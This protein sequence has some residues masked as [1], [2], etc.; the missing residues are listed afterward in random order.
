[1][2]NLYKDSGVD[3]KKGD[4]L[5]EWLKSTEDEPQGTLGEAVSGIGG[6]AALF[7]PN[8]HGMTD[9]LLV[10]STDGVGTKVLLGIEGNALDGLGIDLVAMCINDLYTVG[11]RPLF[12]LDYFAT[13]TLEENQFKAILS[14]IKR[15]LNEANCMLLG[16]ETAEL[17]GLYAKQHFDLAG[18]VVGVVDGN[19]RLGPQRVRV[20]DHLIAFR[21]SGFHSNGYS[22]LRRWWSIQKNPELFKKLIEPTKIYAALPTLLDEF[23]CETL[24]AV[25]HITGGG[26]SG[27]LPRVMPDGVECRI[28]R[29]KVPTPGWMADLIERHGGDFESVEGVFNMGCGMIASVSKDRVVQFMEAAADLKLA[30]YDIGTVVSG[31]GS[32]RV[33]YA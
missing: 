24:H 14:G 28:E 17:P 23:G 20:G 18:F 27:N 25:A 2:G 4:D 32:A 22:L 19:K 11:A 5:V 29:A 10:T 12:F 26:I 30:P 33:K 21:S 16:G 31:S 8:F 15:G 7:R 3:V 6:F 9:P 1:M 13:G